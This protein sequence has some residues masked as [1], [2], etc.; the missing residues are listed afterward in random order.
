MDSVRELN[1]KRDISPT[2]D[3]IWYICRKSLLYKA[4]S[5]ASHRSISLRLDRVELSSS[6][7]RKVPTPYMATSSGI[8]DL[9]VTV[10]RF[11]TSCLIIWSLKSF[12]LVQI[13]VEA[14]MLTLHCNVDQHKRI[15]QQ[16][17][18]LYTCRCSSLDIWSRLF[19]SQNHS[20][21]KV[22]YTTA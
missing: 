11:L 10:G 3:Y 18:F 7:F 15:R 4:S 8:L 6:R 22:S 13:Q 1:S 14:Y 12:C 2:W 5:I 17:G 19:E 20:S 21:R 16:K 9:D